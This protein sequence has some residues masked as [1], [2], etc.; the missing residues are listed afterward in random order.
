MG[1]GPSAFFRVHPVHT[2]HS[3]FLVNIQPNAV[4]P[5]SWLVFRAEGPDYTAQAAGLGL[6]PC[7][8]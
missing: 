8:S 1:H 7:L 3:Y 6:C 5:G 4:N 2:V